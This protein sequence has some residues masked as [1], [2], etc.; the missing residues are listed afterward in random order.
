MVPVE[1]IEPPFLSERDFE[2]RASTSSATRASAALYIGRGRDRQKENP[3]A[4]GRRGRGED[5]TAEAMRCPDAGL[6]PPQSSAIAA[7]RK[8]GAARR[9]T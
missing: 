9:N 8:L 4:A 3:A 2:S 1:G 5:P 7:G 6:L